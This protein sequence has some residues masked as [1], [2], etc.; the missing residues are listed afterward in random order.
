MT[1]QL[2]ISYRRSCKTEVLAAKAALEAAGMHIW[3]D[4][5]DIDTLADFPS[6]IQQGIAE[7][8]AMLV[9]WSKDYAESDICMQEFRLAWQHARRHSSDIAQ[10]VWVLNPEV[11]GGHILAGELNAANFLAPPPRTGYASWV[12]DLKQRLTALLPEGRL[13]NEQ[14]VSP[15]PSVFGATIPKDAH[16]AGRGAE[17][18]QIHSLLFPPRVG[19]QLAGVSV[20][21]YGLGGI[22]KTELAAQYVK[23]F[24]VAYPAGIL[25]LDLAAWRPAQP[26]SLADAQNAWLEALQRSVAEQAPSL[27]RALALDRDR[28]PRPAPEVR[29]RLAGYFGCVKPCLVVLND[30]PE[31]SPLDV[32]SRILEFLCAPGPMGKTLITTR[33]SRRIDGCS[34]L[35]VGV[36]NFESARRM[37]ATYRRP[38]TDRKLAAMESVVREVGC[39]PQ[40]L[41]LLG[42]HYKDDAR[43]WPSALSALRE[44]GQLPY[45][46]SIARDFQRRGELSQSARGIAATLAISIEPL[47]AVAREVLELASVAAPNMPIPDELLRAAFLALDDEEHDSREDT[48]V[49]GLRVLLRAS[50]LERRGE[51]D[52]VRIHPLVAQAAFVLPWSKNETPEI[53]EALAACVKIGSKQRLTHALA[54]RL[55]AVL[56]DSVSANEFALDALH[57]YHALSNNYGFEWIRTKL[58]LFL[59][60]YERHCGH[61]LKAKAALEKALT[62]ARDASDE[63][64]LE[65]LAM[66]YLADVQRELGEIEASR[67]LN[68]ELLWRCKQSLG[69][70][71]PLTLQ[72]CNNLAITLA[73]LG[74]LE[75]AKGL[76]EKGLMVAQHSPGKTNAV[77]LALRH[78]LVHTQAKLEGTVADIETLKKI[79]VTCEKDLGEEHPNTLTVKNNLAVAL[80]ECGELVAARLLHEDVLHCRR[81]RL[82]PEHPDTLS[83]MLSLAQVMLEQ[84]NAA[85]DGHILHEQSFAAL[86]RVCGIDHQL[87]LLAL[88]N[89]A[90]RLVARGDIA[91]ATNLLI[92][93][94]TDLRKMLGDFHPKTSEIAWKLF[95]LQD[96]LGGGDERVL[97]QDVL[98]RLVERAPESLSV[99]QQEIRRYLRLMLNIPED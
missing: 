46:D 96:G 87:T 4:A 48:F 98:F 83:S 92:M 74:D 18:M 60:S 20:Q 91:G 54:G 82:G 70:E 12:E 7:S 93:W 62:C 53:T 72:A 19:A 38:S 49:P 44:R 94:L 29:E 95:T 17:L 45:I 9:W 97:L 42:E 33:D 35:E 77:T 16:F 2:F 71:H 68:E 58:S 8:H 30:L 51:D 65:L 78:G 22:G 32:R 89:H 86:Q 24:S 47:T 81:G 99:D 34:M 63:E 85:D 76:Q 1:A 21:A 52:A 28:K 36:L 27:Y 3:L 61:Y 88:K 39:H 56:K 43:G 11:G 80:S 84:E 69:E 41:V 10:R 66:G 6:R 15:I 25:W 14:H 57:A 67:A 50:L 13:A 26:A 64:E 59:G 37:L 31:L 5:D 79:L 23:E 40:A 90:D 55:N 73:E 75:Q